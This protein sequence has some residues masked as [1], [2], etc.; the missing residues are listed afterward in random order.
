[1]GKY[2]VAVVG[3][4]GA[5]GIE[6]VKMLESRKFPLKSLRL[7]ASERS[8]GKTVKYNGK[9]IMVELLTADS[10]RILM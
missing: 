4:T 2:R 6:M 9:D 5:V 1:V 7:L 8:V 10:R 3:A